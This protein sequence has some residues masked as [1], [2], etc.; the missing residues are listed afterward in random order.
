MR[1][2]ALAR[3]ALNRGAGLQ[4]TTSTA[5]EASNLTWF[6]TSDLFSR[7]GCGGHPARVSMFQTIRDRMFSLSVECIE[8]TMAHNIETLEA[9]SESCPVDC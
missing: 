9:R 1:W 8:N 3:S 2:V 7:Q 6:G 5:T 4:R